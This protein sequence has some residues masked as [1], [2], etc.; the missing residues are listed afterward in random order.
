VTLTVDQSTAGQDAKIS[1]GGLGA[2]ATSKTNT[3]AD[4]S[5]GVSVTL[6][7][8][9]KAGDTSTV[10]VAQDSS[11]AKSSVQGLVDQLN[12]LLTKID[13]L[14]APATS[15]AK[16]GALSGDPTARSLR[17]ALINTVF[18]VDG[19]TSM[20]GLGIQTDRYGKL[21]F[22]QAA[23]DKAYAADPAAVAAQFTKGATTATD[24]WAARL[25]AVAGGAS[26]AK[27][28]TITA[29]ITGQQTSIDRLDT[30]ITDWDNRLALRREGL[31]RQF[32]ALETALSTMKSQGNWLS[33]QLA[34]LPTSS[35]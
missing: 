3:F 34:T 4:V 35:S 22:D 24:G 19:Q 7:S 12:A 11:G 6:A 10:T 17:S 5:P 2:T 26:D 9:A 8:S 16:A 31:T 1:I 15:T 33:S 13:G 27:T 25:Q 32:T 21:V 23:F 28:G 30:D 29:A 14:T 20:A 18:G